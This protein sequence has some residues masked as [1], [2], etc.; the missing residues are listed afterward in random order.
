[1]LNIT[2]IFTMFSKGAASADR[3]SEVCEIEP[4]IS[5]IPKPENRLTDSFIEFRNVSFSYNGSRANLDN[6]SFSLKKGQTLGIIGATGCG[7]STLVQLL[8]R[9][10]DPDEGTVLV[11]GYDVRSL[12]ATELRKK[13]GTVLQN[14]FIYAGTLIDN[15]SF[16]RDVSEADVNFALDNACASEFVQTLEEGTEH[17]LNTKGTNLSGGQRQRVLI[18]RALTANPEILIL[19]DSSSALDYKTDS[20][21]R[22]NLR[23]NYA[24]TTKVIVAQRVSS[25]SHADRIIVLENGKAVGDGT[26]DE[27]MSTCDIYREI[28]QSQIGGEAE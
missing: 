16:G 6:V 2:R 20:I 22:S 21:L 18:T 17:H 19:D 28:A 14:D 13:F 7:K 12:T 10:Y 9:F 5:Y 26:H 24:A 8:L 27:L 23:E 11:D 3:I 15:I 1:M 4:D 25:I